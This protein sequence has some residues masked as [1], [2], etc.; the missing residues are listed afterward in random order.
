MNIQNTKTDLILKIT[1]KN[2]DRSIFNLIEYASNKQILLNYTKR[3]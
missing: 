2:T 3:S 1:L